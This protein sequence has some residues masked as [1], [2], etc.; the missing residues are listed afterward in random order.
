MVVGKNNEQLVVQIILQNNS[1]NGCTS[2]LVQYRSTWI[3]KVVLL[4]SSG[5]IQMLHLML[6]KNEFEDLHSGVMDHPDC[7]NSGWVFKHCLH[8]PVRIHWTYD[9]STFKTNE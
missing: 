1:W 8:N 9:G 5:V 4:L 2:F 7:S 3:C 6:S